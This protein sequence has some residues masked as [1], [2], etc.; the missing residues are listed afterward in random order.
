MIGVPRIEKYTTFGLKNG[1]MVAV[2]SRFWGP[3]IT[4]SNDGMP[5][6]RARLHT[7]FA[8]EFAFGI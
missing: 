3:K 6:S 4:G 5:T 7:I 2:A 1:T 8:V